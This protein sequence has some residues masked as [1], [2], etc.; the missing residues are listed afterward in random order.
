LDKEYNEAN[1]LNKKFML[2]LLD[3]SKQIIKS[4]ELN[5]FMNNK[6]LRYLIDDIK[7]QADISSTILNKKV[8]NHIKF[9]EKNVSLNNAYKTK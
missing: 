1:T 2:E 8:K 4:I 6:K 3:Y 7:N 9:I 5:R